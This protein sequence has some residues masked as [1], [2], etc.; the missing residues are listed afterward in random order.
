ML[1]LQ[2]FQSGCEGREPVAALLGAE[3]RERRVAMRS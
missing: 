1:L 2:S 3:K